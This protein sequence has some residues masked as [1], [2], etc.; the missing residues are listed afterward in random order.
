MFG[1]R[2]LKVQSSVIMEF[3]YFSACIWSNKLTKINEFMPVKFE[4]RKGSI[5]Q[6]DSKYLS[7]TNTNSFNT[8]T[9]L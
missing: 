3:E 5:V 1:F 6:I 8:T 7:S 9:K 2:I 4:V